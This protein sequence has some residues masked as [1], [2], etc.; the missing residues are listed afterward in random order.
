MRLSYFIEVEDPSR[1]FAM[2]IPEYHRIRN[3]ADAFAFMQANPF[4]IVVSNDAG[5]PFAT[6][7][8]VLACKTGEQ[9]CLRGHLAKANAHCRLLAQEAETLVIFHGP[10][11]YISPS[12]YESAESVPTWNYAAV[13][14][15]GRATTITSL[16]RLE[17]ILSETIARFDAGYLAQWTAMRRELRDKM[18]SQI[19]GF[20]MAVN[21]LEGKFKL[22]QNR[23][24]KDQ[25]RVIASLEA[26]PDST[27]SAV[28][29]LMK[30]QGLG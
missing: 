19:V 25:S 2:Y 20:E 6:H 27:A 7:I 12:L 26:S 29:R 16:A 11:A 8:P 28:A 23:S 17:D 9:I 24:K 1:R 4:A 15:Y 21:R 22:S 3:P 18:L 13:H 30:D 10:H 5:V 14:A